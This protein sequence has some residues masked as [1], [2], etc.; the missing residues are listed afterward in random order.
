MMKRLWMLCAILVGVTT[1]PLA[2]MPTTYLGSLSVSGGSG[3]GLLVANAEWNN[4]ATTLSWVVDDTTTPGKW[5]YQYTLS[6]P[7]RNISHMLIEVSDEDP[8]PAFT[9][10]N[11][12]SPTT[13]P[14]DWISFPIPI[15]LWTAQ[16][17][18][19]GIPG[20][21]YGMKLNSAFGATTVTVSFDSDRVPVWGDFYAKD[22]GG[23][24]NTVLLYNNGFLLADPTVAPYNGSEQDHLLV[25]DSTMT[26]IPAP[27]AI[28]LVC[29]GTGLVG[30]LRRRRTL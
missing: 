20:P 26:V 4:P 9:S 29:I 5:H 25:P 12:F 22:G 18:N 23:A 16:E 3:D 6:V 14:T 15:Q 7:A 11:L 21:M 17:G 10:A 2:A 1:V 30:W 24:T 8:G 13:N 28:L 19:F 27:G